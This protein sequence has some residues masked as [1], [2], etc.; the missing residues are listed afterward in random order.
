MS[1]IQPAVR[2][3]RK[4]IGEVVRVSVISESIQQDNRI[5]VRPIVGIAIW[6]EI[7]IRRRHDPRATESDF[8]ASDVIQLVKKD[9]SLV[10]FS[11][12]VGIFEDQNAIARSSPM[13]WVVVSFC[14]P[15]PSSIINAKP[16]RLLHVG[17]PGKQGDAESLGHNHGPSRLFSRQNLCLLV[18]KAQR[19]D[20]ANKHQNT[21]E[22][23]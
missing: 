10:I 11:I 16:D 19:A 7:K 21:E 4:T 3:P 14:N 6:N 12:A 17:F 9:R 1:S 5:A 8:N 23:C 20:Q 15:Q 2:S 18:Y 13:I 22:V